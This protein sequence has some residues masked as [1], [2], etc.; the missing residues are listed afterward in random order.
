MLLDWADAPAADGVTSYRVY[1][2]G[3]SGW[4]AS[5]LAVA[6]ESTLRDKGVRPK[7]SYTYRVTAVDAAGNASAPSAAVSATTK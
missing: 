7:T 4:P 3:A 1:Q 5:P 2:L 6:T